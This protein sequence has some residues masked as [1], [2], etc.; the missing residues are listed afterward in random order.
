MAD[1]PLTVRVGAGALFMVQAVLSGWQPAPAASAQAL[2]E[3]PTTP[4]LRAASLGDPIP[5]A[6]LLTLY[7][8]AFDNQ[9]GISIPFAQ[10][11]YGRV[12]A[13]LSAALDLDP[14]GQYPLLMAAQVYGQVPDPARQRRMLEF[15]YRRFQADPDRR[16][17]WLA[18]AAIM[19]RHRLQDPQ[20]ALQ[21]AR[22]LR[23]QATGPHVPGW[24]RQME[25]FLHEEAGEYV[26]ARALLGGMLHSG[27]ITDAHE[28]RFLTERLSQMESAENSSSA[29]KR[30]LRQPAPPDKRH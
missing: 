20:L 29:S 24:A 3:V 18:H 14:A 17:R 22:A 1:V 16:W 13:W 30:R 21:Y 2:P 28:L 11:D 9:P 15:V 7:L 10:L 8:Q 5:L 26:A 27:A 19:A 23:E 12:E 6:Q 25:I 4:V